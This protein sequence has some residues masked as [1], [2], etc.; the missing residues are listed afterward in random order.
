MTLVCAD[1]SVLVFV[2]IS[3][4][5][6]IF[7]YPLIPSTGGVGD[8]APL[9]GDQFCC[10]HFSSVTLRTV[11]SSQGLATSPWLPGSPWPV[12]TT[13]LVIC[14]PFWSLLCPFAAMLLGHLV[15]L[16]CIFSP[17]ISFI[18]PLIGGS[19]HIR[20]QAPSPSELSHGDAFPLM[21]QVY[22][23]PA[24]S[25]ANYTHSSASSLVANEACIWH[26]SLVVLYTR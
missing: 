17:Q 7:L 8:L 15:L 16:Y 18:M 19:H 6:L 14:F 11:P 4:C 13:H 21:C 9:C 3:S 24:D 23:P 22:R 12:L 5:F 1:D 2:F 25:H 20:A 26:V 10:S